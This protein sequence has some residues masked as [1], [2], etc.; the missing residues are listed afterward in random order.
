MKCWLKLNEV[1][2][3]AVQT[4][5]ICVDSYMNRNTWNEIDGA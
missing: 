3:M 1:A 2:A 5:T 4:P